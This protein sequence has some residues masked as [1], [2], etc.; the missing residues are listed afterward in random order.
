MVWGYPRG[1]QPSDPYTN[2]PARTRILLSIITLFGV[3][4]GHR[5]I[6]EKRKPVRSIALGERHPGWSW[7][8][9][10]DLT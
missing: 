9:A 8:V 3:F 7:L 1:N 2:S 6:A 5:M 4:T 10:L